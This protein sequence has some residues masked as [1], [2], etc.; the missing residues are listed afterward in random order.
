MKSTQSLPIKQDNVNIAVK[1]PSVNI[2]E[3]ENQGEEANALAQRFKQ[4]SGVRFSKHATFGPSTPH[5]LEQAFNGLG[6]GK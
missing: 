2:K 1:R 6:E 4:D 3:A 5:P